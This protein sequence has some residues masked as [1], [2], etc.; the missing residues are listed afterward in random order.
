MSLQ[1]GH[2]VA[3]LGGAVAVAVDHARRAAAGSG[4]VGA[5]QL[6]DRAQRP[7]GRGHR[8]QGRLGDDDGPLA[9]DQARRGSGRRTTAGSR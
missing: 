4:R 3:V 8:E 1:L 9:R 2:P 5:A 7:V 6:V